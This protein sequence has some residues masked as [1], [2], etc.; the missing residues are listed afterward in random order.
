MSIIQSI[1]DQL[2][3]ESGKSR[4]Y[5]LNGGC[6]IFALLLKRVCGGQLRYLKQENHVILVVERSLYDATGNV[7]NKYKHSAYLKEDELWIRKNLL[8]ELSYEKY[9]EEYIKPSET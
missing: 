3:K 1:V 7:T 4:S 5:F 9:I 8:R 2:I 6:L